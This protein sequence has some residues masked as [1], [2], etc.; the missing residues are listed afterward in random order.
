MRRRVP[1]IGAFMRLIQSPNPILV[2]RYFVLVPIGH[3]IPLEWDSPKDSIPN[4][5]YRGEWG[6]LTHV[7]SKLPVPP[8][9][10][11]QGLLFVSKTP[12]SKFKSRQSSGLNL[13]YHESYHRLWDLHRRESIRRSNSLFCEFS[14][15]M[16][17]FALLRQEKFIIC[18]E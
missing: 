4:S 18:R 15:C 3:T 13:G 2:S 12:G 10:M 16:E 6:L 1:S 9:S 17:I 14:F 11:E 5:T 7:T 8:T